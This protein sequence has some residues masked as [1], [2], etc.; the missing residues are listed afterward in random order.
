MAQ[1]EW[2]V[3]LPAAALLAATP[4]ANQVL[5]LRNGLRCGATAAVAALA[6]RFAAFALMVILVATGLGALLTAS[7]M[8]LTVLKWCGVAYLGWLGV[9]I[10]STAGRE[11]PTG[12]RPAAGRWQLVRQE[13]LVAA[14]N[15]KALLLFTVFLPQFLPGGGRHAEVELLLLGGAYIGVEFVFGCAY[16]LLGGRLRALEL[17]SRIRRR[18]DRLTG[19]SMIGLAALLATARD[20]PAR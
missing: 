9:R 3:F 6:G 16:A 8:A 7:S 17:S 4:G 2:L 14:A 15:P 1:I 19:C 20:A 10:L 11:H 18:L 13:C 12:A 5:S